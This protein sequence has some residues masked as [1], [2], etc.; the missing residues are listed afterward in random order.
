MGVILAA[1]L[2]GCATTG[3][4]YMDA[5]PSRL[6]SGGNLY[7]AIQA[8]PVQEKEKLALDMSEHLNDTREVYAANGV[9]RIRVLDRDR[10][11]RALL[12]MLALGPDARVAVP[13]LTQAYRN[14]GDGDIAYVLGNIGPAAKEAVPELS[15]RLAKH[16]ASLMDHQLRGSRENS[17]QY[18]HTTVTA[19]KQ[20]DGGVPDTAVEALLSLIDRKHAAPYFYEFFIPK[21]QSVEGFGIPRLRQALDAKPLLKAPSNRGR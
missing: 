8:L 12:V 14:G 1:S 2:C 19:L 21:F 7:A 6:R 11:G 5:D 9:T 15:E 18:I 3:S 10:R 13:A 20:I 4:K 17:F 16:S